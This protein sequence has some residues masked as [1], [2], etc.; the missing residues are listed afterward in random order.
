MENNIVAS[1]LRKLKGV[2]VITK[3][4]DKENNTQIFDN[5]IISNRM[6]AD[7]LDTVAEVLSTAD[8]VVGIS[9]STFAFLAETLDIP[10]VI[11]DVWVPKPR[12]GDERY[13][14][15]VANESNAITK[16][17]LEDLNKT[18]MYQLK[19]PEILREE[20]RIA[21]TENGG[22]GIKDPVQNLIDIILK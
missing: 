15:F 13:K 16:C 20:R 10:V 2:K 6:T 5:P 9:E 7:H 3:G 19:H 1:E 12:A 21:S 18:I 4:L 17:K 22:V 14:D 11:P 8:L